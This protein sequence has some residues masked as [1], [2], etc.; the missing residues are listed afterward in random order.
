MW[1]I[2]EPYREFW[3]S[4][5][6]F[7]IQISSPSTILPF[8]QTH[9]K[10]DYIYFWGI[11]RERE[12]NFPLAFSF[13]KWLQH[14]ELE[15]VEARSQEVIL[16]F[17]VVLWPKHVCHTLLL[18]QTHDQETGSE[19]EQRG[20]ELVLPWDAGL[21]HSTFICYSAALVPPTTSVLISIAE[22]EMLDIYI[23]D[24]LTAIWN[25]LSFAI[26][27]KCLFHNG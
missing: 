10:N 15:Q 3:F 19:V 8:H 27:L 20:H 5:F 6:I 21:A 1:S 14:L 23:S 16:V 11:R 26:I 18:S 22:V 25:S 2:S 17:C 7:L 13:P 9:L 4:F 12:R 24:S